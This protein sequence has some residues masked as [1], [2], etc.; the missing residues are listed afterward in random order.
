MGGVSALWLRMIAGA[1][2]QTRE[3]VMMRMATLEGQRVRPSNVQ[4]TP[5]SRRLT[6]E[7]LDEHH[8]EAATQDPRTIKEMRTFHSSL[9][10]LMVALSWTASQSGRT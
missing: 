7:K 3:L 4:V 9:V 1:K 8:S 10:I 6:P 5:R 2:C